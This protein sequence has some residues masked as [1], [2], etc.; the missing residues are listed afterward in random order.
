MILQLLACG[1]VE[2]DLALAHSGA[3]PADEGSGAGA[4]TLTI[5]AV[6]TDILRDDGSIRALPMTLITITDLSDLEDLGTLSLTSPALLTGRLIGSD[7]AP[8]RDAVLPAEPVA[9]SAAVTWTVPGA[10]LLGSARADADGIFEAVVLPSNDLGVF[11]I[12]PDD[13]EVPV[14]SEERTIR[15]DIDFDAIDLGLG[16]ALWGQL[17]FGGASPNGALVTVTD[18][19]GVTSAPAVAD[20]DGWYL[21]RV[22]PG[23]VT[24]TSLGRPAGLDPVL[25]VDVEVDASTGAAVDFDYGVVPLADVSARL[26][27]EG[28]G[29]D[30]ATVRFVSESL[31]GFPPS[32]RMTVDAF[33]ADGRVNARLVPGNWRVE[34][35]PEAAGHPEDDVA[36]IV[37]GDLIVPPTGDVDFGTL[38][39]AAATTHTGFVAD[40]EGNALAEAAITCTEGGDTPRSWQAT[41]A[42]DGSFALAA[43]G[44]LLSCAATP[45]S[46]RTDLPLVRFS[47]SDE[48]GGGLVQLVPEHIATGVL[49]LDDAPEA[50]AVVEIRNAAGDLLGSANT[51]EE[52]RFSIPLAPL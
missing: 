46:D 39:L 27:S 31:E 26:E 7:V 10:R 11:S 52:G 21:L 2:M 28:K 50:F 33:S 40:P 1:G 12:V 30:Q 45:P 48:A 19:R 47:L 24:V 13:P 9:V 23:P 43:P 17:R 5:D 34:I 20:E 6:P 36:R 18:A 49:A 51:D 25:L 42:E 29:I 4:D 32:A 15:G 35:E 22:Q 41:T 44:P 16:V 38:E 3:L 8:W 37:V 14:L